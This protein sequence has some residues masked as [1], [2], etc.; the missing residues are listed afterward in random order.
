MWC[1]VSIDLFELCD[2]LAFVVGKAAENI[3]VV[4]GEA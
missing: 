2:Q 1:Y 3:A 4:V